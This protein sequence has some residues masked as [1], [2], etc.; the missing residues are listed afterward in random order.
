MIQT[1][2]LAVIL[3]AA[4]AFLVWCIARQMMRPEQELG[5]CGCPVLLLHTQDRD[6]W[7]LKQFHSHYCPERKA[8][9][10][11]VSPQ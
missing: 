11:K 8:P 7:H 2:A 9:A 6:G 4:A 5:R 1:L 10:P 3:I